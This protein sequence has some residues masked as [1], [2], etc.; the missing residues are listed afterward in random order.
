VFDR[1]TEV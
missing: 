1:Q